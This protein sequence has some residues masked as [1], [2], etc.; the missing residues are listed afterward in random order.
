MTGQDR[1]PPKYSLTPPYP[2]RP[3]HCIRERRHQYAHSR[4]SA[5]ATR[6]IAYNLRRSKV[7]DRPTRPEVTSVDLLAQLSA[8]EAAGK[9]VYAQTL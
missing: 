7:H 1:D 9:P 3:S 6:R 8:I 4:T 2:G 5:R